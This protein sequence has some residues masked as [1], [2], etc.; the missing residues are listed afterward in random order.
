MK[1]ALQI[2]ISFEQVLELVKGL[3]K[4]QKIELSKQLEKDVLDLFRLAKIDSS[5]LGDL[6]S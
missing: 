5:N 2:E 4:K 3:S 1:T 6:F